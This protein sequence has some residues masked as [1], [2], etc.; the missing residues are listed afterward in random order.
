MLPLTVTYKSKSMIAYQF[1]SFS[2]YFSPFLTDRSGLPRIENCNHLY[3]K[4]TKITFG[5]FFHQTNHYSLFK[6]CSFHLKRWFSFA[7]YQVRKK[8]IRRNTHLYAY[9]RQIDKAVDCA[10]Y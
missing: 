8:G 5:R 1:S 10:V 4:M 2:G 9:S 6:S 3:V 7:V